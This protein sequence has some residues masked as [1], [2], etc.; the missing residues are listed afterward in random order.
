M[1]NA[2]KLSNEAQRLKALLEYEVLDTDPESSYDEVVNLASLI[3]GTPV[4]MISL[5]DESRQWF[6]AKVGVNLNET[7]R[8]ISFCGHAIHGQEIFEISD[9]T[10][11]SR[12]S[13]N[14]LVTEGLM[15]KFYAGAPLITPDGHALG[16]LCVIDQESH[17]LTPEH[18]NALTSL[19]KIVVRELEARKTLK[20]VKDNFIDLKNLTKVIEDQRTLILSAEK[21][22]LLGEMA[23]GIAHEVNKP[24]SEIRTHAGFVMRGLE[25]GSEIDTADLLERLRKVDETVLKISEITQG[26]LL[27]A[28]NETLDEITA[29]KLSQII[30]YST[31]MIRGSFT[32]LGIQLLMEVDDDFT[33]NCSLQQALQIVS[34]LLLNAK[35]AIVDE[36]DRWIIIGIRKSIVGQFGEIYIKDSGKGIPEGIR[37]KIM[38]PFFT[39]KPAGKGAGLGLSISSTLARAQGGRIEVDYD[40]LHTCFVLSLPLRAHKG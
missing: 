23:G 26:M 7:E 16:T 3:C 31:A 22:K 1:L 36:K 38:Q 13:D 5:V 18:K 29:V 4:A 27:F 34:N 2:Q 10:Q 9:A 14:P 6:K 39:T 8:N 17:S 25:E 19:A 24:L 35:D 33:V 12:F 40:S 30:D 37:N 21:M 20:T 28:R 11:D 32:R 15:V